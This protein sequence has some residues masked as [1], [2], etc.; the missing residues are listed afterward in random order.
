[1][2]PIAGVQIAS[3]I[4]REL[5]DV[6]LYHED[7]HGPYDTS[8][9]AAYDLVFLTG[10]QVDFDRM[11]QLSYHFRRGGAAVV[12]GGSICTNFPDF[13]S[14]FFDAVCTGGIDS[15]RQVVADFVGGRLQPIYRGAIR[16]LSRYQVDYGV[17]HAAGID[18]V[19]HLVEA[20]RGCS[21]KCSF[22]VMPSEVGGHVTYALEDVAA[23]IE[24]S[25][26]N[27]RW[28]SFRRRYPLV[29]FLDNN[30]S[31]DRDYLLAV[32]AMMKANRRVGGW[33]ALVTQNILNDR[34]LVKHLAESKCML[35]FAGIESF[36]ADMLKRYRKTQNLSKRFNI[37]DDVAYAESQGIAI[38]Y[39]MLF[40]PRHQTAAEMQRQLEAVA[41]DPLLPMPVYL[42]VVAPLAGTQS[43]WE[44]LAAGKLAP[45]LRLRDLDGE[46]LCYADMVD[47]PDK[48]T[49]FVAQVFR[50]PWEIVGRR[51]VLMKT[52]RR[53]IR[54]GS[55]N[56][57][58]WY[59]MAGANLHCYL[60]SRTTPDGARTYRTGTDPLD[61]QYGE[62]PADLSAADRA[63]YFDPVELIDADGAPAPWLRA[64]IPQPAAPKRRATA[65][66]VLT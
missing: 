43:F 11:R 64:A 12:A 63:R 1:M 6:E 10:L 8:R 40:D 24:S 50:R 42:S 14:Q 30:L 37:F 56:P 4:D 39:G 65:P 27:S 60:W 44:D 21:F 32:A 38:C 25:I 17:M 20:S 16:S 46:T 58:R 54:A 31:D 3:L 45:R 18:P 15:T 13:A 7:W 61:P 36:D 23:A 28:W 47:D 49:A 19:L 26:D 9:T 29:M 57:V 22:C 33:A 52:L 66:E 59:I 41:E 5:F 55:W 35:L 34:A 2:Q 48:I 62:H 53:I 51:R